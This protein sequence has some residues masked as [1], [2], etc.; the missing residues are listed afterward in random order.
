MATIYYAADSTV[1]FNSFLTYPQT[2][3]SQGLRLYIKDDIEIKSYARNGRSTR[4]FIAEGR[5][6]RIEKEIKEGD[7]LFIQFGHNDAKKEDPLRYTDPEGAYSDNI[8]TMINVA[9]KAGAYPVCISPIYRRWFNSDG[10]LQ[11]RVHLNYPDCMEKVAKE[12]NVPFIDLCSLTRDFIAQLGDEASKEYFMNFGP[13][14]YDNF[15]DG[16]EDNTHL[17]Y[18]GAVKFAGFIADELKKLG[19]IYEDLVLT[20][21]PLTDMGPWE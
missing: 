8:R 9:K 5:L 20:K 21:W 11:E 17:R 4:S 16:H 6:A 19:G 3:I 10:T 12:E 13:G 18:P 14:L 7:F 15:P 2:G 1:Q